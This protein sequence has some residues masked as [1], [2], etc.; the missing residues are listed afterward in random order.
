[1]NW[2]INLL[3]RIIELLKKKEDKMESSKPPVLI[4]KK[5]ITAEDIIL[6]NPELFAGDRSKW[7]KVQWIVEH[8]SATKDGKVPDTPAIW[9]Y[10]TSYRID[11]EVVSKEEFYSRKELGYGRTFQEPWI[12][13]GYNA[14]I[15]EVED[16]LKIFAGRPLTMDGGHTKGLNT[17]SVGICTIGDYDKET[18]SEEKYESCA[19][20][21]KKYMTVFNLSIQ[22]VIG[23]RDA[24]KMLGL[25]Y[26]SCP[27]VKFDLE[28]LKQI[29]C[30]IDDKRLIGV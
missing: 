2:L 24:N 4:I 6:A 5:K 9:K 15:E 7:I 16:A 19:V 23:H 18:P 14:L 26:K 22:A 21:T 11:H 13:I 1:M 8:H 10:H 3:N 29:I 28:K 30:K 20:L 27:G 25:H 17:V 12:T